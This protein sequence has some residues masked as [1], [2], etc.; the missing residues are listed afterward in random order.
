MMAGEEVSAVASPLIR[1]HPVAAVGLAAT[2]GALVVVG[3]PWRWRAF[4]GS[5]RPLSRR[6]MR[7]VGS[8]IPMQAALGALMALVLDQAR[9]AAAAEPEPARKG[10]AA[11][12][13]PSAPPGSEPPS[14]APSSGPAGPGL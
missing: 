7:W 9:Q 1:R 4:G 10:S 3:R 8:Q 6:M 5:D 11:G 13:A 2:I 12:Q 14:A